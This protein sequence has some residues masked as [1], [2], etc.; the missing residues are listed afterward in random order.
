MNEH[1]SNWMQFFHINAT[2]NRHPNTVSFAFS[3]P[4]A[5]I[6]RA[7]VA[8]RFSKLAG[9]SGATKITF[10]AMLDFIEIVD[11]FRQKNKR[12]RRSNTRI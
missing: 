8:I 10:E 1:S 11:V 4:A 6:W 2:S 3:V 9:G 7:A 5:A 12:S